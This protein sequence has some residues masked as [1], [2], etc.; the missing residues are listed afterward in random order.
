MNNIVLFMDDVRSHDNPGHFISPEDFK[1]LED[2]S[3]NKSII[4]FLD[5][6]SAMI[7]FSNGSNFP[8][9]SFISLDHDLG[10]GNRTGHD[11]IKWLVDFALDNNREEELC[12]CTIVSHSANPVGRKNIEEY[13]KNFTRNFNR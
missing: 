12:A 3:K 4:H 5:A 11:F 7:A 13:F 8:F 6:E 1:R 9:P 2:N 10:E